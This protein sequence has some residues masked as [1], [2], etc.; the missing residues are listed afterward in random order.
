MDLATEGRTTVLAPNMAT[1]VIEEVFGEVFSPAGIT[2]LALKIFVG[3]PIVEGVLHALAQYWK[4]ANDTAQPGRSFGVALS[5]IDIKQL[6]ADNNT[7]EDA[8]RRVLS[9]IRKRV[10]QPANTGALPGLTLTPSLLQLIT[11]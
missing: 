1:Q 10:H 6:A 11:N 3:Q 7:T 9:G 8:I 5:G 2:Q 4:K